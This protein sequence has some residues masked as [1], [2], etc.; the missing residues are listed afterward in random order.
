MA[1]VTVEDCIDKIPN[2]F[3]L[4]MIASQRARDIAAGMPLTLE[5]DN[6]KN[7]VV[8]LRE[9]AEENVDFDQLQNAQIQGMQR[10][11]EYDEPEE[12]DVMELLRSEQQIG[13][14]DLEQGIGAA[15]SSVELVDTSGGGAAKTADVPAVDTPPADGSEE[16]AAETPAADAPQADADDKDS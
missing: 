10:H 5:R 2:R 4:V 13:G 7:P 6:D 15:D 14:V 12:E 16:T 9:I 3:E 11:I 1:R 8:A